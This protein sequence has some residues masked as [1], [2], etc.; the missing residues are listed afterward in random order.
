MSHVDVG[1]WFAD[2]EAYGL[3]G[4]RKKLL[5]ERE[6]SSCGWFCEVCPGNKDATLWHREGA[7]HLDNR[8]YLQNWNSETSVVAPSANKRCARNSPP[9]PASK[10]RKVVNGNGTTM[11]VATMAGTK[12]SASANNGTMMEVGSLFLPRHRAFAGNGA[13]M[14]IAFVKFVKISYKRLKANLGKRLQLR[15]VYGTNVGNGLVQMILSSPPP[16]KKIRSRSSKKF[17]ARL[18]GW[19]RSRSW[20]MSRRKT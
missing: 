6:G 16:Q 1:I 12:Q 15:M 20:L 10:C 9:Q 11:E 2:L 3:L 19:L 8:G 13:A 7:K 4:C 5:H 14:K 18:V 17:R